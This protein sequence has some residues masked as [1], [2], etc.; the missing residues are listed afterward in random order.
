MHVETVRWTRCGVSVKSVLCALQLEELSLRTEL[1]VNQAIFF[2]LE[3]ED[4]V[5]TRSLSAGELGFLW[6]IVCCRCSSA[7]IRLPGRRQTTVG[8][9]ASLATVLLWPSCEMPHCR[10]AMLFHYSQTKDYMDAD[11]NPRVRPLAC[12]YWSVHCLSTSQY[13]SSWRLVVETATLQPWACIWWRWLWFARMSLY[14]HVVQ[15]LDCEYPVFHHNS[16][17]YRQFL[18]S[19]CICSIFSDTIIV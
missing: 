18:A 6:C 7:E 11:K 10:Q 8:E 14:I 9:R 5:G 3:Q 16:V 4:M 12:D 15:K 13:C 19:I 2:L 17:Q 1:S